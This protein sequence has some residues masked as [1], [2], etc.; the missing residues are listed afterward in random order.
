MPWRTCTRRPLLVPLPGQPR[1]LQCARA[2][3]LSATHSVV[4]D[5]LPRAREHELARGGRV[6][7]RLRSKREVVSGGHDL[8]LG[9]TWQRSAR[10]WSRRLSMHGS[11]RARSQGFLGRAQ[12]VRRQV[13]RRSER[14]EL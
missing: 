12:A 8:S 5:P 11:A 4:V 13:D 9:V 14:S 10:K 2:P 1:H 3:S 7:E 6:R